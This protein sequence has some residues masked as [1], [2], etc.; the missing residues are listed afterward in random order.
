MEKYKQQLLGQLKELQERKKHTNEIME[1]LA[2]YFEIG[3]IANHLKIIEK[4]EKN[5]TEEEKEI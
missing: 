1:L 2:I 3:V 4:Q 5:I